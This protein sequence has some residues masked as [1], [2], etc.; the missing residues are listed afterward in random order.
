MQ[1][2]AEELLDLQALIDRGIQQ[3]SPMLRRIFRMPEGS[4][5]A[6]QLTRHFQGFK[7]VAMATATAK[8]EPRVAPVVAIFFHGKFHVATDV[9]T[10]RARH[11]SKRSA[12]SLTYYERDNLAVIVH[13]IATMMESSHPDFAAVDVEFTRLVGMSMAQVTRQFDGK[14]PV[15][16][17]VEPRTIYTFARER[18]KFPE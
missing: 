16:L 5:S 9:S 11:L 8:G 7:T 18:D 12:V 13:G 17:R 1:E 3:A 2:T 4:L 10:T 6:R 14:G 15:A